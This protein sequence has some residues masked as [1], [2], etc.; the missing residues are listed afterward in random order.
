M[1][2]LDES[3]SA[4]VEMLTRLDTRLAALEMKMDGLL[5]NFE[6][7]EPRSK[8]AMPPAVVYDR[9]RSQMPFDGSD[10]RM[11]EI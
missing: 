4:I 8:D 11:G 2:A 7:R 3:A 10:R 6:R 9:R 5:A 1:S